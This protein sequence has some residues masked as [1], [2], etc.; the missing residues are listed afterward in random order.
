[1]FVILIINFWV[2]S[3]IRDYLYVEKNLLCYNF[4][5][6]LLRCIYCIFIMFYSFWWLGEGIKMNIKKVII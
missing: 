6:N 5:I 1:M 3:L 2:V 4:N